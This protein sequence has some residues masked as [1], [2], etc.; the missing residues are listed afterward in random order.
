MIGAIAM[1]GAE[2][3][4]TRAY[5]S[6][7][8]DSDMLPAAL[9]LIERPETSGK[10]GIAQLAKAAGIELVA[11]TAQ[12]INDPPVVTAVAALTQPYLIF[13]GPAGAIVRKQLFATGKKFIHVHPGRLPEFRGSTTIY[14]SLLAENRIEATALM[15]NEVIDAGPVIGRASFVPPADRSAIDGEYDSEIRASLLVDVM[16]DFARRGRF[17]EVQQSAAAGETYYIIHPVLKHLAIL[18][19]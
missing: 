8:R 5:L 2:T 19:S 15:L 10:F 7:L 1:F 18:A 14:Y 17:E 16:R 11:L 9:I 6:A 3:M 12:D 4:R 13:S